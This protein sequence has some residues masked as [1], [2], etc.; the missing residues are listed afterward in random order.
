MS[1]VPHVNRL[2]ITAHR[3]NSFP[4]SAECEALLE[5][6]GISR[7][8]VYLPSARDVPASDQCMRSELGPHSVVKSQETSKMFAFDSL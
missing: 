3:N 6:W 1:E 8:I 7:S 4:N 5:I 2:T